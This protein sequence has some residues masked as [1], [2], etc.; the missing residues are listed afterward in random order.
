VHQHAVQSSFAVKAILVW[1]FLCLVWG[2]TWIFIKLGLSYLPP[3]SFAATRFTLAC[4]LLLPILKIQKIELPRGGGQWS[5]ILMTGLLQ[6]FVNYGSVFWGEQHITSGL[7][8]VLQ[9]M[10]PVFGLILA[11]IIADEE[12]TGVKVISIV[13]GLLGVAIIFREQLV[14]N[15]RMALLG[16][17]SLVIGAFCGAASSVLTKTKGMKFHPA[18]LVFWQ[19]LVGHIPLWIVGFA[20][21]GNPLKFHWTLTAIGCVVYLTVVGS[22]VAFWLYYWLLSKMEVTRAMMIAFVT[23][24]LAVVIGSIYGEELGTETLLGGILILAAVFM[25]VFRPLLSGRKPTP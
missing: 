22:I 5:M 24:V 18:G 4:I 2:T 19:M 20:V 6:F 10:I 15:G 7:A 14:I 23:P 1:L 3:W 8:A 13:L 21:D 11:K 16:S 9:A 12:I 17:I 25:N